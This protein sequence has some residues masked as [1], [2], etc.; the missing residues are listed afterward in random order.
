MLH[1]ESILLRP[2]SLAKRK[3]A[4]NSRADEAR[5]FNHELEREIPATVLLEMR[6]VLISPDGVLSK[7]GRILI[8][9]FA[10]PWVW[11]EWSRRKVL[12]FLV[13]N[14]VWRQRAKFEPDAVW[15][16]DSWSHGYFHWFADALP[17]LWAIGKRINDLV[18]LL[19]NQY[20]DI[21][22]VNTSLKL[23]APLNVE[24]M[25]PDNATWCRRLFV[26]THTAPSGHYNEELIRGVRQLILDRAGSKQK[27]E[28]RI[29][30]SRG[31]AARR[32]IVNEADVIKILSQFGFRVVYPEDLSLTEQVRMFSGARYLVS[33]HGAGLTNMLFMSP[34]SNVLELRHRT[35]G[36]NNCYFTMAAALEL[37]YFY[38]SCEPVNPAADPHTADL[39]VDTKALGTNLE[40]MLER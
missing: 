7:R 1:D 30:I 34:G 32:K 2:K 23:F 19:P 24:F 9:S 22:F 17:R 10:F 39:L 27:G 31:R 3:L 6:D 37:N 11:E 15:I 12:K 25:Q 33:N 13:Q 38:Q 5:L 26:P 18:L 20:K 40:L 29:Y 4:I 35:D 8:E 14:Y 16:I 21:E 36:I 28:P